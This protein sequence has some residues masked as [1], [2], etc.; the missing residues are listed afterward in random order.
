MG[1]DSGF[2][3]YPLQ[4]ARSRDT[5]ENSMSCTVPT[6]CYI[7]RCQ[8]EARASRLAERLKIMTSTTYTDSFAS[9]IDKTAP[10]FRYIIT[11]AAGDFADDF[12]IDQ[13]VADYVDELNKAVRP[14]GVD[15][16]ASGVATCEA[17]ADI[18][19]EAVAQA[20]RDVD[21]DGI[22]QRNDKTKA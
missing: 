21:I 13:A 11:T 10:D 7:Y 6:L 20:A 22:L 17:G 18:D 15:V 2:F 19:R 9:I 1:H 12:D 4:A 16:T 14:L 3:G 8:Q 5:P